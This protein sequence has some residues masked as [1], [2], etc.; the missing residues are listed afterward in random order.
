[1]NKPTHGLTLDEETLGK[2]PEP[3]CCKSRINPPLTG[4]EHQPFIHGMKV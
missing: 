3:R 2:L 4:N 1:M